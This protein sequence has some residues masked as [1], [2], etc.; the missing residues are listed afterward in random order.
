MKK[1]FYIVLFFVT[2]FV[3]S[4]SNAIS[5]QAVI[6]MPGGQNAPGVNVTNVPMANK[7]ICLQFKFIDGSNLVEYQEEVKVKTDEFGMV[8]ITIGQGNQT[9][10]YASNFNSIVWSAQAQKNLQVGLDATGLCSRFDELSNE[11]IASVPFANAAITAG[12]VSGVVAIANG[13]TGATTAA[14]AR[15]NLGIGN[16]D[17]TSDLNKPVSNAT[18]IYVDNAITGATIVDADATTKGKLQLAGDLAG[19]AAA[20]RVP[21]LALKE[22][23]ANKSTDIVADAASTT[24]YPS[25]K[26]IKD[27][28]DALNAAAGVADGSIT[29]AKIADAT[30]VNADVATNAAIDFSKLNIQKANILGLGIVK[31][32]LGLGNIDNTS[33]AN[34]PVSAATQAALDLKAN[35][36]DLTAEVTRATAAEATLTT[37]VTANATAIAAETTRATAAEVTLTTNVTA[38]AT[39]IAAETTRATAAET[40]LTNNLA[41]EVTRATAAESTLTTNVTA[42]ATAIAAETTRATAAEATL[43]N[44]LA[45]EVTRATAAEALK[46]NLANKSTDITVDA[47]STDKY[48]SVKLIKDYVD[49]SV[50]SGAPDATTALKGKIKLAGDLT[51][52][53]DLPTIATDAVTS[54]KILDGTIATADIANAAITYAKIQNVA[55]DK[56]L[57]RVSANAGVVEEIA[58]TGS[59]DVVR[60]TSPTLVTPVLG[61]ATVTSVNG[62]TIPTSKTLVVTTDKL[63]VMA[64]TTSAELAGVVS[65]ETGTG[66]IVFSTSPTLVTPTLGEATATTVNKVTITAPTTSATL[67]I[68]DGKTLTASDNA[69]ISGTNTG[70][71]TIT[72]TGDVTGTGTGSFATTIGDGKV[73]N[74][75]LA[76][77]IDLTTKVSGILPGANGGTGVDNSGK[78]ITLGGNLTTSGAFA[79]TLTATADSNVTLPTTGTLATL[80]GTETLTNKT[81]TSPTMTTPELGVATASSINKLTLTAPASGATLTIADGKTLTASNSITLAGTDGTTMTFPSTDATIARTDADQTFTG[82]QTFSSTI[83]GSI[84][85]NAATVTTNANLTGD[86]TSVGNTTTIGAN[87]VV[88][89]MIADGTIVAA[90]IA[91]DAIEEVKIKNSAVTTDKIADVNVTEAKLANGSVTTVKLAADAVTTAK[92]LDGTI[93]VGDLADNAIETDKIKDANVTNAKLDKANIPLSGFGAATADVALG[94]KKLT[95][96]GNPTDN[97]DVATKSYVDALNAAAGVAD[98]SITSAKI[99]DATIVDADVAT[100]AAIAYTKL[101]LANSIVAGDITANAVETAKINNAAVTVAKLAADAVTTAKILDGTILVDDLA[102]DAVETAKIKDANVTNAKLDK[103]NI[104]LSGFGAATTDVAFGSNKLTGVAD[105]STAQDAATKNYVDTAT[106]AITTLADGKIYLGNASNVA[107]EVIPTGDVTIT[108]AGV[109]AIGA[110]KVVTGMLASDAVTTV[111][112]TDANVTTAKLADAAVTTAKILNAN[113]TNEKLATGIDATKLADGSVTNTELQYIGTLTSDVQAQIDALSTSGSSSTIA[114]NAINTLADGKI[115]IGNASNE[116]TEVTPTGDVTITNAGVTAIGTGKVVTA[117]LATDAVTTAKI[118]NANVTTD[119]LAA[120]AVTTAKILDGTILTADIATDAVET[121]KIKNAAVTTDKIADVNVTEAKLAANAVTSAKIKDGEIA[122]ADVA[123]AAI[124]Y[125]KIQNV[126]AGKVLGNFTGAADVVEEIA[127]TGTGD[128]VRATSP[129]LVTPALGTPTAINLTNAT[130]LPLTT[131]VTGVLPEANGGTGSATKNFVDLTTNQTID[132]VKTF[133]GTSTVVNQN[134]TVNAAGTSGQGIILSD[135]GDIVDNND[136]AA[137]F[138]FHGGVKINNGNKSAGTAT[139][140]TLANNGN[141][142]ATGSISGTQLTSTVATGTAPLVVTSTTPVANLNIGGNAATATKLVTAR[143]INTVDFDGSADITVTAAAGTLTGDTL[144]SNVLSSSLTSVGTITTGTWNGS[145]IAIANGGTGQTTKAAAFDALSPMTTAGD[146]V[147]GGTNGTGTRLAKGTDG[148]VLVLASGVPKWSN[149]IGGGVLAKTDSYDI[150]ATDSANLVVYSGS[151]ASKTI[152]LPSAVDVGAGR[153]ITIKNIASVSVSITASAGK[154]ISDS[155]TTNATSLSI[156]IE[157]SNNWIKAISDGTNWIILR[158][159]F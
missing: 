98:G 62:T 12:N 39:A 4:Q 49:S 100:T 13:G 79:T 11:P 33:D 18:K 3:F 75:M 68:A 132:G 71:Q 117:M 158:A 81:L 113:V 141:I 108:N 116:A 142:T 50:S 38:N 67:T 76:G 107:T 147:Y 30:I 130:A 22:N 80:A 66:S 139:T 137:T 135:D 120:D 60:A 48:P 44:N 25:V 119:K 134:L 105:P 150:L 51:G 72:L 87:K 159:L 32:D 101:N 112:I 83:A 58:T 129:T 151:A 59:G 34:K 109:T 64:A 43:T 124:T 41:A 125:A 61:V 78:T 91:T 70:D 63:N 9:G 37:N 126:A 24:K 26:V 157:P 56:V 144:A 122:T 114:I 6:Y 148:Q 28:V 111:K 57:G 94:G 54:A 2:S 140:I 46:E 93:L 21:G 95:G 74:A 17:N 99:A 52:T 118:T 102:N 133:S 42:N 106:S 155:T 29:S 104:P 27:Y 16:V 156:G 69:T 145:T 35:A 138:R 73:T 31:G 136:G 1:V 8:N 65:D 143:K 146:I 55:A 89:G 121:A 86:V 36:T 96:V 10:G 14:G 20:P 40:T 23:L 153:E 77:S 115:Y 103:A 123:N 45:A 85:G 88:T 127:T 110:G 15:T 154:L 19:T 90:D 7:N 47:L 82:T 128:V 84:T 152:K 53:A 131:G 92:I 97:Q 149:N 5:Y